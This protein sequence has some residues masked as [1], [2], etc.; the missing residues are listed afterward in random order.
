MK[1]TSSYLLYIIVFISAF[2]L[3]VSAQKIHFEKVH[4]AEDEIGTLVQGMTQDAKG[5]LWIASIN[6]LFKYD[7]FQYTSYRNQPQDSSS[8]AFNNLEC[9]AADNKGF[10]WIGHY[11]GRAGLE[12]LDPST[13]IFKHFQH[14][15]KDPT[16]ISS[17]SISALIQARDGTI[18]VGTNAGL[19]K[20]DPATNSFSHFRSNPNDSGSLSSNQVRVLYEDKQGI[21]WI[22]TGN[23]FSSENPR[24]EGGLNRLDVK[25]GKITRY[26]HKDSDPHTLTDNRI[27][28]IFEDSRGDFWVGSCGDGLH[29]M[30]RENGSFDRLGYNPAYPNRL[31]R[32]PFR[33]QLQNVTDH[34][35][36]ITED[37]RG[38]LWIGTFAGGI[39]VYDPSNGKMLHFGAKEDSEERLDNNGFWTAYTSRDGVIWIS[40]WGSTLYKVNPNPI[41]V[42]YVQIGK[43]V[44]TLFEDHKNGLWLGT[45]QGLV[46]KDSTGKEQV[47][48]VENNPESKENSIYFVEKDG[49]SRLWIGTMNHLYNFDRNTKKF[50]SFNSGNL[51]LKSLKADSA[52]AFLKAGNDSLIVNTYGGIAILNTKAGT[53][54]FYPNKPG[55][56]N[57]LSYKEVFSLAK[58][59]RNNVWAILGLGIGRL[60]FQ[61]GLFRKYLIRNSVNCLMEDSKGDLWAASHDGLYKY[62]PSVDDFLNFTDQSEIIPMVIRTSGGIYWIIED[63]DQNLWL[64]SGKGLIKLDKERKD[65]VL[66]GKNQGVKGFFENNIGYRKQ[67]G[68][69][70]FTS[71]NGYYVF[72]KKL[73]ELQDSPPVVSISQFLFNE[74]P[75]S[76]TKSGILTKPLDQTK[77]IRLNHN[78]NTFSFKLSNIDFVSNHEDTRLMYMLQNYE[79]NWQ[80]ANDTRLAN[81]INLPPGK[82]IFRVKA[83]NSMGA[84]SEKNISIVIIPPWW[85]RWWAYVIYL[86]IFLAGVWAVDRFQ[87][88]R[89]L[90]AEQKKA[91]EREL[92]HAREIEKAYNELRDT[93]TALIHSEKMAS[94]GELTAG[95]AHEIQNPLN[96]VNNFAEINR[97]LISEV[98]SQRDRVE[99]QIESASNQIEKELLN[100]IEVNLEKIIHHGKRAD[101]IVKSMLQHSRTSTG[102]KELIDLNELTK[103][104]L[105]L[106]Y[107]GFITKE[108]AF[109]AILIT[110]YDETLGSVNIIP[111]DIGRVLLNLFNNAFYALS[112]KRKI[113]DAEFEPTLTV[114]T[115]KA[116]NKVEIRVKDN[117]M[118]IPEKNKAKIFQ[119][120]FT[121]KAAGQGTGLGLSLSFD[122]IVKMHGGTLDV[123]SKD[124]EYT[125]FIIILPPS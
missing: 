113:L 98:I 52:N 55:N 120:F 106:A 46:Y 66:L 83:Y 101:A 35:T 119:P 12:R 49:E 93:Q 112:Q 114:S 72:N 92:V 41:R 68:E 2:P 100:D 30:N 102:K 125:C 97:E 121:T 82:Y 27:R 38:R 71:L 11:H 75:V 50:T 61:T 16:S 19:D 28:A 8:L 109:N 15:P 45:L 40:T 21:I 115:K 47:Y 73:M 6:G 105:K 110:H 51:G 56:S 58:D 33:S 104:Y 96:Y 14:N 13:G 1:I 53:S 124:G 77:E 60:D 36:F 70:L 95:I 23:A 32:P 108:K 99:G 84:M 111:Q 65:A 42:P 25:T 5:F 103:E 78:Q 81:Y 29:K 54:S 122:V 24:S 86:L 118:G 62:D 39:N 18:W 26:L 123:E 94:L 7:G 116:G 34:I 43:L 79:K 107:F 91:Q 48:L 74:L 20:Y 69:L 44:N 3:Q 10:I 67:N 76:P 4:G 63:N 17:D 87:K 64:N 57:S 31:S 117:G 59:K 88:K 22:G 80:R 9:I 85:Q 89:L 37:I 90:S